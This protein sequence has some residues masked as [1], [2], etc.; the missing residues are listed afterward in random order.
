MSLAIAAKVAESNDDYVKWPF[1]CVVTKGGAVQ[2]VGRNILKS[3][4]AYLDDHSNC[5]VHAEVDALRQMSFKA[6]GCVMFIARVTK[7]GRQALAKPCRRC[8]RVIA[9]AGVKRVVF[10]L[11]GSGHGVWKP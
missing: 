11:D 7:S 4:P 2:A 5:S 8:Q 10:T 6:H 1:G 3:D 9:S